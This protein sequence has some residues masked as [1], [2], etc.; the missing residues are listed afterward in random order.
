[1]RTSAIRNS[2]KSFRKSTSST[3][4]THTTTNI[5]TNQQQQ[6]QQRLPTRLNHQRHQIHHHKQFSTHDASKN[7]RIVRRKT[8]PTYDTK[9]HWNVI[10]QLYGSVWLK[11]LPCCVATVCLT[12]GIGYLRDVAGVDLTIP[13]SGQTFISSLM[14][15]FLVTRVN[16]AY[17]RFMKSAN[18]V[19]MYMKDLR[20]L[21]Q[22][23]NVFTVQDDD[24]EEV[25]D[26]YVKKW[27]L[28]LARD[29]ISILYATSALIQ[30]RDEDT[31]W[32][33]FV[34]EDGHFK[35]NEFSNELERII[36]DKKQVLFGSTDRKAIEDKN[37]EVNTRAISLLTFRLK[38]TIAT[39]Q[40]NLDTKELNY[41]L[42]LASEFSNSF[43]R[44]ELFCTTPIPFP[45]VQ[46]TKT[47]LFFW[48]FMLPFTIAQD[49][50]N[51][52]A[53]AL[54][55][56]MLVYG[57]VGLEFVAMEMDDPFGSDANDMDLNFWTEQT[58]QNIMYLIKDSNGKEDLWILESEFKSAIEPNVEVETTMEKL[59]MW[60][61]SNVDVDYNN[62]DLSIF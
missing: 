22:M 1:M 56:F 14:S 15:F 47:L 59:K 12:I 31:Y 42:G 36:C 33:K 10:C 34:W 60:W 39:S 48:I 30:C 29:V 53:S 25:E 45:L 7:T 62:V 16:L 57:F 54:I 13:D 37:W 40:V 55:M 8:Y 21:V 52:H 28:Q 43:S 23:A 26:D 35:G 20:D 17:G 44:L 24:E 46:L 51:L 61:K 41:L 3:S 32:M 18:T 50:Q 6:Q 11:V 19:E 38:R 58:V 49:I 2:R 4:A 27:R 9:M 5:P